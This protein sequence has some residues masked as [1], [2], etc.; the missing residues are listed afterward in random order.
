MILRWEPWGSRALQ[1]PS[2]AIARKKEKPAAGEGLTS[3]E[4]NAILA[5]KDS[6][7]SFFSDK[8]PA[9]V[10]KEVLKHSG[11]GNGFEYSAS[12]AKVQQD[13]AHVSGSLK[14]YDVSH[15]SGFGVSASGPYA[16]FGGKADKNNI[17]ADAQVGLGQVNVKHNTPSSSS[18]VGLSLGLG[19]G[20][21]YHPPDDKGQSGFSASVGPLNLSH[22][23]EA[24]TE[25]T[26]NLDSSKLQ[27]PLD[28][29]DPFGVFGP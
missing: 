7:M 1:R 6:T 2:R 15:E 9:P 19:G 23:S 28:P 5:G 14:N 24:F 22:K 10:Q 18:S 17:G 27:S 8:A 20:A 25:K 16:A 11:Q 12:G 4:R 21:M 13:G 3:P 26:K 29:D